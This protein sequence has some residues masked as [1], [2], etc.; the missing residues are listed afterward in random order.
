[1][2]QASPNDR[3]QSI[4]DV[5][6]SSGALASGEVPRDPEGRSDLKI[7]AVDAESQLGEARDMC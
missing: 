1:M 4:I 2:P 7:C 5:L 6:L 3:H